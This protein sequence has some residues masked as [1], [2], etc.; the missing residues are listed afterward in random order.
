M[1]RIADSLITIQLAPHVRLRVLEGA[2]QENCAL[3]L[4][5]AS[6]SH[7]EPEQWPGM[8]HYLEHL[9]FR[10][11]RNYAAG[12]GLMEWVQQAGGSINAR[13]AACQ[14]MFHF[15]IDRRGFLPALLRLADM[16]ACPLLSP[17][18]LLS[19][20]EV[21]EQEYRMYARTPR[22]L[23][24]ASLGPV[25]Q[26]RHPARKFHAGNRSTLPVEETGF[27]FGLRNF[28]QR[29]YRRT[30]LCI[31]VS[32]PGSW[33]DWEAEVL[34]GLRPLLADRRTP[35]QQPVP[36]LTLK[37]GVR[38]RQQVAGAGKGL[39]LHVVLQ[40]QA[41]GLPLLAEWLEQA[42]DQQGDGYLIPYLQR[43]FGC[44][45]VE[46]SVP[47]VSNSQGVLSLNLKGCSEQDWPQLLG[48]WLGWFE[49][50]RCDLALPSTQEY[51]EQARQHRWLM[52]SPL[53]RVQWLLT[54]PDTSAAR[55][56]LGELLEQLRAGRFARVAW[57]E[58]SVDG[59]FDQGLP[60][61]IEELPAAVLQPDT[62]AGQKLIVALQLRQV[63]A[64]NVRKST[65]GRTVTVVQPAGWPAEQALCY[66]GWQL[67]AA[68]AALPLLQRRLAGWGRQW[69]WHGVEWQLQAVDDMLFLRALGPSGCLARALN[70]C[71][72][73]L[74]EPLP[75]QTL[76]LQAD[77]PFA[78][79]Q[80]MQQLTAW[81]KSGPPG[82]WQLQP[83][84]CRQQALWLGCPDAAAELM[85]NPAAAVTGEMLGGEKT[86][87]TGGWRHVQTG[88]ARVEEA[89][90]VVFIP[91]TDAARS[92]LYQRLAVLLQGP[93]QQ[94][95]R[96]R[97]G[98]C[99]A[100]FALPWQQA[101]AGGLLLATQSSTTSARAL[102]QALRQAVQDSVGSLQPEQLQQAVEAFREE[103]GQGRLPLSE[104]GQWLFS[105]WQRS[106]YQGMSTLGV[107]MLPA[108][109]RA[110]AADA[111]CQVLDDRHWVVLSNQPG[112][113]A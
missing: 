18:A 46:V 8:A 108:T 57:G 1:P 41:A 51:L 72:E 77:S 97:E 82:N 7:D 64:R 31:A 24:A 28:H 60:L 90:L 25:L 65:N 89:L 21:L 32:L 40:R 107:N 29:A 96:S 66:L 80:L 91:A 78:L 44:T 10:G 71:R 104:W 42:L 106:G 55:N 43:R 69:G 15:A 94:Q 14:T 95:L 33:A 98:L 62:A 75:E 103:A 4:S 38:I 2:M 48:V 9:V 101:A 13:T 23:W 12:D 16:L 100:V 87:I 68:Q 30:P 54:E 49:Q 39:L 56:S 17:E 37:S 52:A 93:L 109:D 86:E 110:A 81:L 20:R 99:Y 79:R 50:W 74:Q 53:E 19:E 36:L 26:G 63:L 83:N 67:G 35:Q 111:L 47:Y 6:G 45:G 11:S 61:A 3:A 112:C 113:G 58:E 27:L 59:C 88:I 5:L 73:L 34:Q 76:P 92:L 70:Q 22:A 105:A 102:F 85:L 84:Q